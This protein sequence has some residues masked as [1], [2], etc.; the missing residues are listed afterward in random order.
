MAFNGA[1]LFVRLYN[2]VN[3]AANSINITASRMDAETDGIAAGLSNCITRDGQGKPSAAIDWNGQ[4]LSNVA[5]FTTTGSIAIGGGAGVTGAYAASVPA[6]PTLRAGVIAALNPAV[7]WAVPAGAVDNR[8]WEQYAD[9]GTNTLIARLVNDANNAATNWMTVTR[10]GM[11]VSSIVFGGPVSAT[12]LSSG[13]YTPTLTNTANIAIS[14]PRQCQWMRVGNVV[15]VSG[16]CDIDPT[17]AGSTLT[18]MGISLPIASTFTQNYNGS[19]SARDV[20]FS[21]N[22]SAAIYADVA[23]ARMFFSFQS[24]DAGN[25][26][27]PFQFTYLILP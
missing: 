8:L 14:V 5:A 21:A 13:T 18:T 12:N 25:Q 24:N 9:G 26:T 27:W 17:L 11:A 6:S 20:A 15:T 7:Q 22:T 1:G 4:N 19:G 3:D 16:N 2:W 23:N 10:S